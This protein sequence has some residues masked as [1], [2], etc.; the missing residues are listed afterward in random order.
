MNS[1]PGR[2][3][4]IPELFAAN[5]DPIEVGD[6]LGQGGE[7]RVYTLRA[8]AKIAVKVY[9][10]APNPDKQAKLQAMAAL[11]TPAITGIAAWP[12]A[13]V[14]DAG[15][16][17]VG[18]TMPVVAE[19]LEL[20]RLYSPAHRKSS[21]PRANWRFLVQ[22][23]RN[24][25]AA[26]DSVHAG[27][28]VIGDLNQKGVLV[29]PRTALV[30]L[31]DCDSFQITAAGRNFP[32]EVG[33]P[34]FTAPE[35]QD[36]PFAGVVRRADQDDFAL[37][38]LVFHLLFL[39]RHP[40]A[41]RWLGPGDMPLPQAIREYRFAYSPK[42]A[43][44]KMAPP[45]HTLAM[46]VLPSRLSGLFERAF[47]APGAGAAY[48]PGQTA[49]YAA[50]RGRPL[51]RE[52]MA[53]LDDLQRGLQTCA[54]NAAHIYPAQAGKCP[55]C[56]WELAT[57]GVA[58][59]DLA[60]AA[61]VADGRFD[62]GAAWNHILTVSPPGLLAP[63][64]P[65]TGPIYGVPVAADVLQAWW[66]YR[67]SIIGWSAA[68]VVSAI[69][70]CTWWWA[71]G[72]GTLVIGAGVTALIVA[73]GKPADA[74]ERQLRLDTLRDAKAKLEALDQAWQDEASGNRF[75]ALLADAV[76]HREEYISLP[77]EYRLAQES[78]ERDRPSVQLKEWLES[79]F[80]SSATMAGLDDQR[81]ATLASFGIETAED[82][83]EAAL[84]QIPGIGLILKA[85]LLEWRLRL[86]SRYRFDAAK[87][88][89]PQALVK[90]EQAFTNRRRLLQKSLSDLPA[91]LA[92][93]RE[94]T[95]AARERLAPQIHD[96]LVQL[97]QAQK[98]VAVL[99]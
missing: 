36:K 53:A 13:T 59:I 85:E 84:A 5:G 34:E 88:V 60:V 91:T 42:A 75:A 68:T 97:A 39:G 51:A 33:V 72:L 6:L 96:A 52:W 87:P 40:F 58:F 71:V 48:V 35:L 67:M 8:D 62:I 73:F 66:M 37:A 45:P 95:L 22:T 10:R 90:I 99:W 78:I 19:H 31:I 70:A 65:H 79:H 63:P 17:L 50:G 80:I 26:I 89:D 92:N 30:K 56:E 49:A 86:T 25:A 61:A 57:G 3:A 23:A 41:G 29:H 69:I 4:P 93:E 46:S 44:A 38:L 1:P 27:G 98:D 9:N 76:N 20:H 74:G 64:R 16:A 43:A 11:A 2:D 47:S 12:L 21:F 14:H 82:V 32:C 15:G 77:G 28:H 54:I 24:L 94:K 55:W 7:G 81:R 83:T 18:F